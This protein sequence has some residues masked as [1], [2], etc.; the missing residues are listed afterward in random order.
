MDGEQLD[1]GRG[2]HVDVPGALVGLPMD[3]RR[4]VVPQAIH[5]HG[6]A[7]DAADD[8]QELVDRPS[9]E[10]ALPNQA[11]AVVLDPLAGDRLQLQVA[12]LGQQVVVNGRAVAD[13]R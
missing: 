13:Q 4:R 10:L 12:E 9:R 1:L 8:D 11:A 2:Q 3:T 5:V 7:E 6:V